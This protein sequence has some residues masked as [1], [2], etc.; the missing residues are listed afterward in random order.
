ML[1]MLLIRPGTL[2]LMLYC[3]GSRTR[4]SFRNLD[5]CGYSG[6]TIPPGSI[7]CGAYGSP[8]EG[9]GFGTSI[10]DGIGG[11]GVGVIAWPAVT[12]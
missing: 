7:D 6:M 3:S 12:L 1:T 5:P 11:N 10:G 4:A 8:V 9:P 2:W